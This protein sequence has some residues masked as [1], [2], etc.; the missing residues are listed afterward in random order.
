[1][2]YGSTNYFIQKRSYFTAKIEREED[3]R[4]SLGNA[5]N[6]YPKVDHHTGG[7]WFIHR[8]KSR[9]GNRLQSLELPGEVQKRPTWE[10]RETLG[11][12]ISINRNMIIHF[13]NQSQTC[14]HFIF[15]NFHEK[16]LLKMVKSIPAWSD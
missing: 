15:Q 12:L 9:K 1:M 11:H 14:Q 3:N 7:E 4:Q 5:K 16:K 8:L 2:E 6:K 13:A 10:R